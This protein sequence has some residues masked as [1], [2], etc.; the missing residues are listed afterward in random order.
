MAIKHLA[1]NNK[2]SGQAYQLLSKNYLHLII[3]YYKLI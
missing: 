3:K 2:T 1:V